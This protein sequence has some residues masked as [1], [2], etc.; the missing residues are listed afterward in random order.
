MRLLYYY[1]IRLAA[2]VVRNAAAYKECSMKQL[3]FSAI[4]ALFAVLAVLAIPSLHSSSAKDSS[5]G[6]PSV[7]RTPTSVRGVVY[8]PL[9]R[10]PH[11]NTTAASLPTTASTAAP[12]TAT[13]TAVP[14]P[15]TAVPVIAT[16][17]PTSSPTPAAAPAIPAFAHIFIIVLENKEASRIV[18][19]PSAPYLNG[20][21]RQYARA[22]NY[23]GVSHPS[24]PNYL[25][26]TGGD[27][28]G[29]TSDCT[30]CFIAQPNLVDQLEAAGK[31]WKAYM[32]SMPRPCYI[33]NAGSL[34]AQKHNPFI[35]YDNVRNDPARCNKIVPFSQ[36]ATDMQAN[37]VPDF[38]WITPNMC[39]DMHDC[40]ITTGDRWL[41][42]WVTTIL[43]S[44]AW[45]NNGV[46]FITFDEG[47]TSAGC[48]TYAA[49]GKVDTLVISP[50]G[51]PGF[52]SNV[53]YS[54]YA[55]LRT[56]TDAWGLPPLGNAGCDCSMP[57][58]EFFR[59]N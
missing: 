48:C 23:Y 11:T 56:I 45:Q 25:A 21:A 29:I 35:Y 22:T 2:C 52:A 59:A 42:Q 18:D 6:L 49:G 58:T 8:V 26:L 31:S 30:N 54:H 24:L 27:T 19:S 7:T 53:P 57:L 44:P 36:F 9:I 12:P 15:T 37:T 34:Y 4:V 5:A 10:S 32:E 47:G 40:S 14:R 17:A 20:L 43:A 41:K 3:A 51:K 33:G 16:A 46:L 39:N 13:S 28:F 55:L 50:L 38:V 1:M